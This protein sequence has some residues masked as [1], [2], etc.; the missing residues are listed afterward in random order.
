MPPIRSRPLPQKTIGVLGGMS[1]QATGEY[2]R[3]LNEGLNRHLGGWDN[4]EIV[5]VSVNFGNIEHFVRQGRWDEAR[6]YL[7]EKIDRL[8]GAGAD[9]VLCVSNTMHRV[10]APIMAERAT[11]FI[12]IADP[13][14]AAI[15]AAGL[16][17]VA[18]LGTLPTMTSTDLVK[19]YRDRFGVEVVTPGEDDAATVDHIIFDE[20]VRR[21][22]KPESKRTYL[23]I[24]DGLRRE[25][26]QG[27]ILGC[28]EIFLLIGADD[29]P[30][31]HVFD[32]AALH[33]EAAVTYARGVKV[34][35]PEV[36]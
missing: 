21:E 32:T 2:Y 5:I 3:L 13:T 29:L 31:F 27:V 6:D 25:G 1:N 22:L 26:A 20:L 18:L 16:T 23:R 9:V 17:R 14:G 19:Y 33:V 15:R 34:Y 4:G 10:V 35:E 11:P 12:H 30:G 7:A 24:V 28:T 36:S 8:E